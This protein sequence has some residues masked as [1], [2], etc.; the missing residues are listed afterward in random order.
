[1]VADVGA[2]RVLHFELGAGSVQ[3][4]AEVRVHERL[5]ILL[6]RRNARPAALAQ[7]H[8]QRA[9]SLS[10]RARRSGS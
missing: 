2:F 6:L 3:F 4:F 7:M 10:V 5:R 9:R 1:M 8:V